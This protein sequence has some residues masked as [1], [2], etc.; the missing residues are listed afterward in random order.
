MAGAWAARCLCALVR[1]PPTP[2]KK[3]GH[4]KCLTWFKENIHP[5]TNA[6]V[7]ALIGPSIEAGVQAAQRSLIEYVEANIVPAL[8]KGSELRIK[9]RKAS[10]E[11]G[12]EF[13]ESLGFAHELTARLRNTLGDSSV[14]PSTPVQPTASP[15]SS[16]PR[17]P[18]EAMVS[19]RTLLT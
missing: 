7:Q 12:N 11:E 17:T 4:H 2:F 3:G 5:S 18:D 1:G 8:T 16:T 15:S 10:K 9:N 19:L 6:V 13:I 14:S